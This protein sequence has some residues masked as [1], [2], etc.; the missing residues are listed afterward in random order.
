[1]R[2]AS[3]LGR[4]PTEQVPSVVPLVVSFISMVHP[5]SKFVSSRLDGQPIEQIQTPFPDVSTVNPSSKSDNLG[6]RVASEVYESRP[7]TDQAG[8]FAVASRLP[9]GPERQPL[10]QV[11]LLTND[12]ALLM[13][14]ASITRASP[15][16]VRPSQKSA[17]SPERQPLG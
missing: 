16:T 3:R 2:D 17:A 15:I 9:R 8:S 1:M 6:D 7:S 10:G 14:R 11:Q 4:Q 12:A 13:S 5:S